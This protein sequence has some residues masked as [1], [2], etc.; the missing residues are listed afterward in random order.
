VIL[1]AVP[2]QEVNRKLLH[3]LV[4]ILPLS[5]FYGPYLFGL[6]RDS[7]AF[8]AFLLF[9]VSS[10]VE[11]LRLGN[12]SF[13]KWFYSAFG[14]MLRDEERK[15]LTGATYV[16]GA[17]FLCAWLSTI[18]EEFAACACLSLTLFILGDAAAALIGKSIGSIFIG[19]K[20]VEGAI[21]CF[22]LCIFLAY[23]AFPMLPLF[24]LTW[25]GEISFFQAFI[26]GLSIALLELF[27]AK[28]GRFKLND[29]LYVPVVVTYISVMI[30]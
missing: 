12:H 23:W 17:T 24:L 14:S 26:V 22:V 11:L 21:G 29:N 25:G 7:L 16:A 28:L 6:E 10:L 4:I 27:P 1:R 13:G 30:R 19:K 8:I 15:S 5:V 20:T 9:L 18:S 3:G 2:R